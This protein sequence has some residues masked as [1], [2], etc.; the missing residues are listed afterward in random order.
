MY[1]YQGQRYGEPTD[2]SGGPSAWDRYKEG[3]DKGAGG[4]TVPPPA[5]PISPASGIF[6]SGGGSGDFF[7]FNSPGIDMPAP[8]PPNDLGM[9]D[10]IAANLKAMLAG[11]TRYT[12][13]VIA[14]MKGALQEATAGKLKG[15]QEAIK[16][17]QVARGMFRS[18]ETG[19]RLDA[20]RNAAAGSYTSGVRD[21]L[22]KKV[23]ADMQD[24]L[25]ALDRAQKWLD[26][27]RQ[28]SLSADM[29]NIQREQLKANIALAYAKLHQD[30]D[31]LQAQLQ[32]Q[33]ALATSPIEGVNGMYVD[34]GTGTR[35]WV[36]FNIFDRMQQ[37]AG[38]A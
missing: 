23:D 38:M 11:N 6:G 22:M 35:R 28:Y 4:G 16:A 20:A 32:Q 1:S 7:G 26:D 37:T 31:S 21:I 25:N 34:D 19:A 10:D 15:T 24:K 27:L 30:R 14:N 36:W 33:W 8:P 3:A 13:E 9:S 17:D 5:P 29:N 18:G 2:I 12:P